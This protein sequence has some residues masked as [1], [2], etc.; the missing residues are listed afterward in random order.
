MGRDKAIFTTCVAVVVGR[1]LFVGA[2]G[3]D[4]EGGGGG[5]GG[6]GGTGSFQHM[7]SCTMGSPVQG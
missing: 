2:D 5:G 1:I 6:G 7:G 4:G 3:G